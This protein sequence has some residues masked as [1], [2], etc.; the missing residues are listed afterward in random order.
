MHRRSF[1]RAG[2]SL[3]A[4]PL[5]PAAGAASFAA[6]PVFDPSD[7]DSVR[8]QFALSRDVIHMAMFY[9][10][11][12]PKP[13]ADAIEGHRR[14]LDENP[15]EAMH[16]QQGV[17][18]ERQRRAAA[19]YIGGSAE[20][21]A[22]TD[23]TTMGL[24]LVFGGLVLRDG[25]EVLTTEH[26]HYSTHMSLEHRAERTGARVRK[27]GLYDDSASAS[28]G[29]MVDRL[30][31]AITD[32]TRAVA[33]TW[34]HSSTGVKLPIAALSTMIAEVNR[35]R[36]PADRILLCI[37]GVHGFGIEG[38]DM[39]SLRCDF[40]IAGTHKWI[41]GPRGTGIIW[42]RPEAWQRVQP[43]IPSFGPNYGVWLGY[44]T[45]EQV[46]PASR[47][48]P[49]GF[50]SFEHR[51]ALEEAFRFHLEIGK[52]RVQARIHELNTR[53][54]E[55]L[56]ALASVRLRTPMSTALSSGII[57]FE[58]DGVPPEQVV[59]RLRNKGIIASTTPYREQYARLAPSLINNEE[60]V[61]RCV[62]A[63]AELS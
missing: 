32:A 58:V 36:E 44:L 60:E 23:S 38:A 30:R 51:W 62:A 40:F 49:G 50:H 29:E 56:A 27:V 12:H 59:E 39:D 41:F 31:K 54:K 3:G 48:T 15:V 21:I 61:E 63:V 28:A 17:A 5:A 45:S 16:A 57:C 1:L 42:G 24:G 55:G 37:D 9:L 4:L 7:W 52:S 6:C 25:D 26:D 10:A 19:E 14:A 35:D 53:M 20:Q 47:M 2:L 46:Q 8:A 22:L 11:S 13:V 18:D 43:V 34:V 33:V